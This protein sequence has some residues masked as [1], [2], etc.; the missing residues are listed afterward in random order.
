MESLEV[1]QKGFVST[2]NKIQELVNRV[3]PRKHFDRRLVQLNI[4]ELSKNHKFVGLKPSFEE[5]VKMIN[6][7]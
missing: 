6:M 2:K 3:E 7:S 4:G 5:R 1:Y